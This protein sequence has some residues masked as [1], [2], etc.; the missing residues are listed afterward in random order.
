M[1]AHQTDTRQSAGWTWLAAGL[2]AALAITFPTPAS[3]LRAYENIDRNAPTQIRAVRPIEPMH[4][5]E[6]EY[7]IDWWKD[8][9]PAWLQGT[10]TATGRP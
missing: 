8:P 3:P 5:H 1:D 6:H 10:G 2:A 7:P 4:G 9:P